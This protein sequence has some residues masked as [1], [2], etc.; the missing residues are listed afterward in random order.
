MSKKVILLVALALLVA[1]SGCVQQTAE[2]SP[3]VLES[4]SSGEVTVRVVN[5][6]TEPTPTENY[7]SIQRDLEHNWGH[8]ETK[9]LKTG[10]YTYEVDGETVTEYRTD[11]WVKNVAEETLEFMEDKAYVEKVGVDKYSV[12]GGTFEGA[13]VTVGEEREG[14]L[15]FETVPE[16]ISGEVTI[17]IGNSVAYSSIFDT[18]TQAP[19]MYILEI[20]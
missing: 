15:L 2:P 17:V 8:F 1:F 12:S 10:F 13:N 3:S 9:I 6:T 4:G 20:Q 19:H 11:I 16:D 14:Y 5:K 18:I 7:A